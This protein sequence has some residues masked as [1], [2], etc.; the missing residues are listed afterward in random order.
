[1]AKRSRVPAPPIYFNYHDLPTAFADFTGYLLSYVAQMAHRR[2][3]EALEPLDIDSR[4]FGV[5]ILIGET[6][7]RSQIAISEHMG[8][9]RTHVVRLIDDLERI[10]YVTRETDPTDRRY[11]RL[12]LT[13]AGTEAL[14]KAKQAE[15][16][17][18]EEVYKTFSDE[19]RATFH[20]L[21]LKLTTDSFPARRNQPDDE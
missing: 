21:L 20:T 8:L 17:A 9:D 18:Q 16:I 14:Q 11:H 15:L 5:L 19:E 6:E 7:H 3:D 12:K 4:Q 2:V 1:M 13:A 10:S